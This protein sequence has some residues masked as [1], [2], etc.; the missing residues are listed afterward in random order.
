MATIST[1]VR[2]DESLYREAREVFEKL[3]MPFSVGISIYLE[4][5]VREQ[6]VP[7]AL[8]LK[9]AEERKPC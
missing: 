1:S 6:G 9:K 5:V 2:I 7:F 4:Y 8:H 3:G